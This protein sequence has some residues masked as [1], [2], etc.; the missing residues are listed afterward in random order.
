MSAIMLEQ[1]PVTRKYS[2]RELSEGARQLLDFGEFILLVANLK[3]VL[4]DE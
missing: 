3:S 2:I 1:E 4:A